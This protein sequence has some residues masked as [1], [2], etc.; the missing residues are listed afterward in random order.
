LALTQKSSKEKVSIN[1][2][3]LKILALL[4]LSQMMLA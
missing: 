1:G 4:A 2:K 3:S